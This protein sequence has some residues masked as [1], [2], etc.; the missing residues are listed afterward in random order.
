ME[1]SQIQKY[2]FTK[3]PLP[4]GFGGLE[5]FIDARTMNIH[6]EKHYGKYVDELNSY[7]EMKP[8]LQGLSLEELIKQH[9]D[10][11]VIR[12]NAGGTYNHQFYFTG[13]RPGTSQIVI[14]L[15]GRLLQSIIRDFGSLENMR[16]H[17]SAVAGDVF[18]SGYAWLC[19][20]PN[21][22]LVIVPTSNQDTPLTLNL[23]PLLNIDVWEHAYYLKHQ[24]LRDDYIKAF[25]HVIDWVRVAERYGY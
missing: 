10:N 19:A 3:V 25:W 6:Y 16:N 18:G 11:I 12:H 14:G 2:P 8:K 7:L 22:K 24:N 1:N 4:Y 9:S 15:G 21:G 23:K 20:Q 5:P 17:F 13:M